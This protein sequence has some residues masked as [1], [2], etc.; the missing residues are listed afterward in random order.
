MLGVML[1]ALAAGGDAMAQPS[2]SS[3]ETVVVTGTRIPRQEFDLP[4][5]VSTLGAEDIE[6]SGTVNVTDFLKRLPA[7][8]GSLG[9]FQTNGYGTPASADGSSLGGLNL[10]DL[11]NL[12]YVRT[13][14]LI[15]GHRVVSNA[16]GSAAVDIS[17]IPITLIDRV[18]VV[19][20][21]A[22]AV[23]GADGVSGVVN[24]IMKHDLEGI[25]ASAQAGTSQ[26][27]GGSKFRGTVSIGHNFDDSRG[28]V[29]L[30]LES[31]WQDHL[32]FTRRSFTRVGGFTSFVPNPNDPNDDPN[33]PDFIPTNDA[34]FIYTARTGAIDTDLDGQPDHLGNGQVFNLGT[35]IGGGSA[36]GSS[37]MPYAEDLQGDFQPME[38]RYIGQING[39]YR[40][41]D[42]L[43]I[44]AEFKFAQVGTKS[45]STAPFDD[46]AII[47][48]DNPYLPSN[49]A[50]L[51]ANNGLGLGLLM[52]DYLQLRNQEA[53]K[54]NTYRGVIEASGQLPNPS[55]LSDLHYELSYVYGQTDVD[56]VN[57]KNRITDR[58]FAALDAVTN[59]ATGRPT[60]RSNLDPAAVPPDLGILFGDYPHFSDTSNR[61]DVSQYPATFTPGANSGC[62]PFNPFNP[63]ADNAASIAFMT[64]DTHT[65]GALT[66]HV[67]SGFVG[68]DI[69]IF[70]EW[71]FAKPLSV[72][73]GA[74]YRREA[75][76]TRPDAI[77][78][79]PGLFWI[80]GTLPVRGSFDVKEVFGEAS[81]T[82]LEHQPFAE[83]LS[84]DV[85]GRQSHYSTAGDSSSWKFGGVYSPIGGIKFRATSAFAVRAPNIGELFAPEQNLFAFVN[86]PCDA[87]FVNNGTSYRPANCQAIEAAL[88]V[89]YTPGVTSTQTDQNVSAL[90]RGNLALKPESART[91]TAGIVLQPDFIESLMVSVDWYRVKITNAISAP[92]AQSVADE[93][94]DLSTI[95]NPFCAQ[96]TRT[97]TGNFPGSI[98]RVLIQQI[99]VAAFLTEGEDIKLVYHADLNDWFN[100]DIG[101]LDVSLVGNHLDTLATTPLPG[102]NPIQSANTLGGGVD[103]APAPSWQANLDLVWH[104]DAFTVDYNI[105]W[106]DGVLAVSKQ[107][108]A[109]QPDIYPQTYLHIGDRFVHDIQVRYDFATGWSAY[110]GVNN[111]FYQKPSLGQ[112]GY[113]VDPLGRFFYV[114]VRADLDFS[115]L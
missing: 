104:L 72:V 2:D 55:F 22:S 85:A 47:S 37:G 63:N 3:I 110:A 27:G 20:G 77:T 30:S 101:A 16:T 6:H 111:L 54:R 83:E 64:L 52:E 12:G 23:Y 78:Q 70:Q 93:C 79:T 87:N 50:S 98:N 46:Y 90:I 65:R 56:D 34:Q 81:L 36:I 76:A 73:L 1:A 94:V 100:A 45:L 115:D 51:I 91:L 92:T 48:A 14:V 109:A 80:G 74:E 67:V 97:A 95:N 82:V 86:D 5:P 59:P 10:L 108:L 75:S 11:R 13:L 41:S 66:Q 33:I 112:N 40:F 32:Y 62:V 103:G 71:G 69:P 25:H 99:N 7:L 68:A 57:L 113:P 106:F 31:S 17:T 29:T 35:D 38:R 102:E 21:G 105:D 96:I 24:F 8:T 43:K 61:F 4:N 19:T 39:T 49:V 53:D 114:G 88:G 84:F 15:D 42:A 26:D 107:N 18:D 89:P 60:C 28:N 44:N 58:F 9:D